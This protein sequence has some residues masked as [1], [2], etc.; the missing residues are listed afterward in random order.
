M[1]HYKFEKLSDKNI[2]LA[3]NFIENHEINSIALMSRLL[4]GSWQ[5][6][7]YD[8]YCIYDGDRLISVLM[9]SKGGLVQHCIENATNLFDD[10]AFFHC[11]KPF[12]YGK[13][14]YCI[15][16]ENVGTKLL[17][18]IATKY[19]NKT[20]LEQRDYIL[21]L[22]NPTNLP[23]ELLNINFDFDVVKCDGS[24]ADALFSL[25]KSYDIVEVLPKNKEFNEKLCKRNLELMLK[26]QIVYAIKQDGVFVAKAGT[27]AIGKNYCQI[28]GVF[29]DENYRG[30]GMAQCLVTVLAKEI[31]SMGKNCALF[32]RTENAAAKTAYR[33]AGFVYQNDY[34]ILYYS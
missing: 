17:Q 23:Q 19:A 29:T 21:L 13:N 18:K 14:L 7:I 34:R 8:Y 28:G 22:Y 10:A 15:M 9:H 27:N 20:L 12:F 6:A 26:K 33:K 25:Q 1:K 16:G 2:N 31:K 30:K 3:I 5:G 24:N 11:L 32:V 4:D